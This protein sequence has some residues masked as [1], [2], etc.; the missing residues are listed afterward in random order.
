MYK[1]MILQQQYRLLPFYTCHLH[2]LHT[3]THTSFIPINILYVCLLTHIT[4]QIDRKTDRQT[5]C[6]LVDEM[7]TVLRSLLKC[8]SVY[9]RLILGV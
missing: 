1:L 4:L 7:L 5:E 6:V 9:E 8:L 2:H 3:H